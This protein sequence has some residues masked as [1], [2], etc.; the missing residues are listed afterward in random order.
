MLLVHEVAYR[1]LIFGIIYYENEMTKLYLSTILTQV[2]QLSFCIYTSHR[3]NNYVK[4]LP[5]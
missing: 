5:I 3:E 4:S 1:E 2:Q